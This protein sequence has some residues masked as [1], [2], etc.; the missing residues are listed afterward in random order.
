MHIVFSDCEEEICSPAWLVPLLWVS[1]SRCVEVVVETGAFSL[2][3]E[4]FRYTDPFLTVVT[5]E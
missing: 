2:D 4:P 5:T 1:D 3:I